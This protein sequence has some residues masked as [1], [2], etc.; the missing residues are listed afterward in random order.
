MPNYTNTQGYQIAKKPKKKTEWD[1]K[2]TQ[3]Q[4]DTG[5]KSAPAAFQL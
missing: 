2:T 3:P 5:K 1:L 4:K